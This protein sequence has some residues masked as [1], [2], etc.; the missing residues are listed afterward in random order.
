MRDG[1]QDDR[2]PGK[3]LLGIGEL[4]IRSVREDVVH[5]I[6]VGGELDLATAEPVRLELERVESTD[7][8]SIRLDLSGL[9]F[10]DSTGVQLL[11]TA[12]ARSRPDSNRLVLV[13]GPAAVQRVLQLSGVDAMPP[14]AD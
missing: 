3:Q 9:T 2:S 12:H 13:R 1:A 5:T 14:F 7:A 6:H 10:M 11:L 4:T 8:Q